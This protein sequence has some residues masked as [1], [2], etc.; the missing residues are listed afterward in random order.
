MT[1]QITGLWE[2]DGY[3]ILA[4]VGITEDY[5]FTGNYLTFLDVIIPEE[6]IIQRIPIPNGWEVRDV[7]CSDGE[8]R[9]LTMLFDNINPLH[10]AI[11]SAPLD[12]L[13]H[14]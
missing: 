13:F 11:Y 9:L 10:F 1:N 3:G 2:I 5:Q 8:V 7:W 14:N 12:S 6:G 4:G